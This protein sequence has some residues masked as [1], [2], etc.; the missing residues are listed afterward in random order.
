MKKI[1]YFFEFI[2]IS[3]LF[4]IYKFLGLKISSHFSGKLFETFGPIFRSKNLIKTNIQRAI[5][6]INS[7]KIKSIT[8]DMW[9]NYGRTLSEYMFLKG[10][11]NDQFRSNINITGKEILQKIKL[12]KTPVIFVSGHFSNFELMAMEIEKSGVNLS[13][14]YRPLNNIFLNILMERIRRKYI[15]KN[16][17][18]K[19]TSGVRELLKLYKK[20]YSIALM[21]DQRVSQGIKSKF[22]NQ[23]AFT[24]TIPAQFIK[25]FNCKVVPI[26]IKRHNSVNFNIKVEKP[27]EFSKNSS[28]E[29]I[30]RELNIWLEKTILKNPGEWIWSHDRWK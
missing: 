11:R 19:G 29:K 8:K 30:T 9:N 21:I 18:K 5:P 10:F 17:I 23:E 25:K 16:Q 26:S 7:S 3:S 27:I 6:K 4:I 24:T 1:K 15:C 22:F 2:I 12:E 13:A 20:G 14:I 28:T